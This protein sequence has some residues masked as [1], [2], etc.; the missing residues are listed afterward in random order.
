M[1]SAF[2][3]STSKILSAASRLRPTTSASS[4]I[5]SRILPRT[6]IAAFHPTRVQRILPLGPQIVQGTVN[7]PVP[8]PPAN[9]VHGSYHW[10]F[11]RLISL[12]MVPLTIA[13]FVAGTAN[14]ALDAALGTALLLHSHIGFDACVTDY[15]PKR[16]Y[17]RL[18][19]LM[20]WVLRISTVVV[21]VGIFSFQTNDVG[22]TETI[23]KVWKAWWKDIASISL[24]VLSPISLL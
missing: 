2:R 14:P 24:I 22:I 7:D 15:F 3:S 20:F 19:S 10:A 18:R 6:S 13:P 21:G 1:A 8:I 12:G 4:V 9:A 11:E 17:P 16:Q 23:K 5:Q